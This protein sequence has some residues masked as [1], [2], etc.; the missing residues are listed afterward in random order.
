M[1]KRSTSAISAVTYRNYSLAELRADS[2]IH[3]TGVIL[4]IVGSIALL[5]VMVDHTAV[6]AYVATTIYLTTLVLSITISAVY[7]VWPISPVKRLLRRFDHSAIYLLIA[8]TYT[9]FMAKSGTWWLLATVWAIAAAGVLLKLLKPN[10]FDRLSIGLYLALGW[11]GVAAYQEL[12]GALSASILWLI[13]A[14]GL[15]Y[16]FGVIF[17]IVE[18]MPFH[19]AIW[20]G[21]VLI[22]ASIHFAAVCSTVV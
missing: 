14:G 18:R 2:A 12:A 17:H 6:G 19:N 15:V 22:A 7:N 4:A 13:L 20:H 5:S 9:P 3:I 11:S 21:L 1:R 10:R 8:G 16:S